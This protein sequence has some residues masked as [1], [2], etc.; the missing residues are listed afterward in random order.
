MILPKDFIKL[1]DIT[2]TYRLPGAWAQKIN[3]SNI[4]LSAIARNFLI[5]VPQKNTFIDPEITNLGNDLIG[6]FGE[7]AASPTTKSV[8]VAL[9]VNF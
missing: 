2:L 1:R 9:K 8:G 5:W 4:S 6:E 7:Q 3:A